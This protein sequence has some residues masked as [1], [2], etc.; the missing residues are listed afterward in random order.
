M[1]SCPGPAH[2]W[3]GD[4]PGEPLMERP[5]GDPV[6]NAPSSYLFAPAVT[7]PLLAVDGLPVGCAGHGATRI[8]RPGHGARAL[9]HGEPV[10]GQHLTA[11]RGRTADT[12]KRARYARRDRAHPAGGVVLRLHAGG[13][14]GGNAGRV[15]A[16]PGDVG[17]FQPA[18]G[19]G[20]RDG[21]KQCEAGAAKRS[22]RPS[23][24]PQR[25][26]GS[27]HPLFLR[28]AGAPAACADER[29]NLRRAAVRDGVRR[30]RTP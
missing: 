10:T 27:F 2:V 4:R 6:F 21:T 25:P 7:M 15:F 1:L 18:P 17:P 19:A 24:V 5:T 8:R 3:Q 12:G 9:D 23:A 11:G 14:E 26:A 28:R 20:G 29:D 13:G 30:H 16:G 22:D